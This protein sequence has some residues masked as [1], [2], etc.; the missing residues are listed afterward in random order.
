MSAAVVNHAL[1]A[2]GHH[3]LERLGLD[4]HGTHRFRGGPDTAMVLIDDRQRSIADE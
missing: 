1:E 3:A 2:A 4:P